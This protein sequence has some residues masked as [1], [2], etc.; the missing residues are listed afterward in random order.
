MAYIEPKTDWKYT[1]G[2]T[3][4]DFNRIEGNIK[5]VGDKVTTNT[6]TPITTDASITKL[7][8]SEDAFA[9]NL[10][11][12]GKTLQNLSKPKGTLSLSDR[13]DV[14]RTYLSLIKPNT[15]YT[16]VFNIL[17]NTVTGSTGNNVG[18]T[19]NTVNLSGE[20]AIVP[21]NYP[22]PRGFV[23]ILVKEAFTTPTNIDMNVYKY[24]SRPEL[25]NDVT[26]GTMTYQSMLLEGN[27]TNK[28]I[29]VYFEGIQSS[30]EAE[31]NK[32]SILSN[33][34]ILPA[35]EQGTIDADTGELVDSVSRCRTAFISGTFGYIN[36][37]GLPNWADNM[38]IFY[39][40][41]KAYLG[42]G[43]NTWSVETSAKIP[44]N[45]GYIKLIFRERGNSNVVP[46]QFKDIGITISA[47]KLEIQLP[48]YHRG[49]PDGTSDGID[50]NKNIRLKNID[51]KVF[52]GSADE[53]WEK[54]A[55]PSE[56]YFIVYLRE[57]ACKSY[58]TLLCDKF[59]FSDTLVSGTDSE[60]ITFDN[61]SFKISILK[62]KLPTPDIAGFKAWLQDNPTTVYYQLANPVSEPLK[63][64]GQLQTFKDGYVQLPNAITPYVSLDYSTNLPSAI[65]E[66]TRVTDG[67]VDTVGGIISKEGLPVFANTVEP[68]TDG[69]WMNMS[70]DIAET[71]STSIRDALFAYATQ[72]VGDLNTLTTSAKNTAVAAINELDGRIDNLDGSILLADADT[73]P[74]FN[75]VF[76]QRSGPDTLNTPYKQGLTNAT[77]SEI[78]TFCSSANN[79]IQISLTSGSFLFMRRLAGGSWLPWVKITTS[80]D[81]GWVDVSSTYNS[82]VTGSLLVRRIWN[83]VFV[84]IGFKGQIINENETIATIPVAYAPKGRGEFFVGRFTGGLITVGLRTDGVLFLDFI[85]SGNYTTNSFISMMFSYLID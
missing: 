68:S 44:T 48:S 73:L 17:T 23:G 37:V 62:S 47:D 77:A 19:G 38:I 22:I 34:F 81:T 13:I 76:I 39:D 58:S 25:F 32:L 4:D 5:V 49:L 85:N 66:L 41:N 83:Q 65:G 18:K 67:L 3:N 70:I 9:Q 7:D 6:L 71:G 20:K 31:G 53:S 63:I 36:I 72:Q 54:S 74:E 69:V 2:V 35:I 82:K 33:Q 64:T 55:I 80:D 84:T 79:G 61:N 11:I 52:T 24:I 57:L 8:N 16:F 15:I 29:P 21:N 28:E 26:A 43:S 40:K 50:I 56:Q 78:F 14:D 51:K 1:D 30:G 46:S 60:V 45:T 12:K 75:K 59:R 27:Y 42:K 10:I